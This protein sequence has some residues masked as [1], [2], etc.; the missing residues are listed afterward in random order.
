MTQTGTTMEHPQERH[1]EHSEMLAMTDRLIAEHAGTI[2]AGT[3]IACVALSRE[4]LLRS[5]VRRGLVAATEAAA[6]L[7]LAGR[8]PARFIA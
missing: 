2:P 8:V 1:A 5:G 6:R 7:R 4:Q 3:V